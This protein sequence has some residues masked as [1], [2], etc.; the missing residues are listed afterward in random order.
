MKLAGLTRAIRPA[1]ALTAGALVVAALPGA[2]A[3]PVQHSSALVAQYVDPVGRPTPLAQ[4]TVRDYAN[5][6]WIPA[7][8]RAALLAGLD[9]F[10]GTA[11]PGGPPLPSKAPAFRQGF[12][13]TVSPDCM[14]SGLHSTGSA[15]GVPG[16][17]HTPVPAPG[18]GDT[19]FVFTAL[20][21]QAAAAQQGSMN[22]YWV[23]LQNFRTGVTP[24]G[25]HGINPTGPATLS[26]RAHTG[27][28]TVL[29]VVAGGVNTGGRICHFAPTA[30]TITVK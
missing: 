9:F 30:M 6:P 16:P 18:N 2:E 8:V 20:G 15:L 4:R 24:L 25:N 21:T 11:G 23:N 1:L 22:V 17:A 3:N 10:A 14:G 29:A 12:W 19:T 5:Q 13:P 27:P 28:G 26:G 7:D